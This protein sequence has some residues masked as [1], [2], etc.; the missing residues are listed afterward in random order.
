VR[1]TLAQPAGNCSA[2]TQNCGACIVSKNFAVDFECDPHTGGACTYT[3]TSSSYRSHCHHR[4]HKLAQKLIS[5]KSAPLILLAGSPSESLRAVDSIDENFFADPR[6]THSIPGAS[7]IESLHAERLPLRQHAEPH[8]NRSAWAA[9][10][11]KLAR[12]ADL[13]EIRGQPANKIGGRPPWAARLAFRT[14]RGGAGADYFA[15]YI[16]G[17][18]LRH[19]HTHASRKRSFSGVSRE[20][21]AADRI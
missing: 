14:F 2:H 9:V 16:G 19:L 15:D 18:T 1:P 21:K 13:E 6:F 10:K 3:P 12:W 17:Y 11:R 7:V 8:P 4:P 20:E 5:H